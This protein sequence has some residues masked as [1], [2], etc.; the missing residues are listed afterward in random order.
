VTRKKTA[1]WPNKPIPNPAS[2][3]FRGHDD[4]AMYPPMR[5]PMKVLIALAD[6]DARAVLRMWLGDDPRFVIAGE[7]TNGPRALALAASE[8]PDAIL[9]DP[10]LP[11]MGGFEVAG[12]VR[13]LCPGA[14]VV[15]LSAFIGLHSMALRAGADYCISRDLEDCV[16]LLEHLYDGTA[17]PRSA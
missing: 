15:M 2:R 16:E 4:L 8:R 17:Q 6:A 11:G 14:T 1:A 10:Y 7:A 12:R 9:V 13:E 3:L 5:V